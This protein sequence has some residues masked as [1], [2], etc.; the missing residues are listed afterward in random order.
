LSYQYIEK[1]GRTSQ[2]SAAQIIVL[3][4][5]IPTGAIAFLCLVAMKLDGYGL[6]FFSDEYQHNLTTLRDEVRPA[7]KY[8]YV[9]QS[10]LVTEEEVNNPNCI[11]GKESSSPP[12]AILWGD[13]NAAH[14]IGII[15][16]F[17]KTG[18]F[19]FRNLQISS[20]PPI[21][22][23][24][25]E[26]ANSK[27]VSDCN[28]SREIFRQTVMK[29]KFVII[30]SSWTSYQSR[31]DNFMQEFFK[32]VDA[33]VREDKHVILI[34]KAPVFVGYDRH[35]KQKSLSYPL[36]ITCDLPS[37][38]LNAQV[39]KLNGK[40]QAFAS[41]TEKVDYIDFN[42]YLCPN[43]ECSMSDSSGN[44]M[45]FDSSHLSLP[46]SWRIGQEIVKKDGVPYP[47]TLMAQ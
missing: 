27:R 25:T 20:C 21:N 4:F 35:C 8:D 24:A 38:S 29:Y 34:G 6:R 15:G 45:Y 28:E 41:E 39:A 10:Q 42:K 23:D 46:A 7:Y 31:S 3:Q 13:S 2:R 47:F 30:S 32:T 17:A 11:V 12:A 16:E 36:K 26:F 9:C 40:L 43:G 19:S 1:P 44:I 37:S 22:V 18:G 14:Y 33:L 5:M